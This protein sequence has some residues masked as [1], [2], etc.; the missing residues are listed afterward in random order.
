MTTT[1]QKA[2]L[3]GRRAEQVAA[4]YLR[5]KGYRIIEKR[6]RSRRGEIDLIARRGSTTVFIEVKAR[7]TVD[8]ALLSIAYKQRRCIEAAAE[9]WLKKHGHSQKSLRFDVVA[10]VPRALPTHITGAW[11]IGE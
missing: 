10:I 6:F 3:R 4:L 1:R 2:E 7:K 8:D 9:D 11:R 5:F